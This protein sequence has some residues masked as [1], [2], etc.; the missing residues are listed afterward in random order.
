MNSKIDGH[1]CLFFFKFNDKTKRK[2]DIYSES[3]SVGHYSVIFPSSSSCSSDCGQSNSWKS[4]KP[5]K[6]STKK[7][8]KLNINLHRKITNKNRAL[9]NDWLCVFRVSTE[10]VSLAT[11]GAL[12]SKFQIRLDFTIQKKTPIK[13]QRLEFQSVSWLIISS[14]GWF[15]LFYGSLLLEVVE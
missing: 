7:T 15:H 1:L 8:N 13:C 14:S 6:S 2:E 4:M 9:L 10:N 12:L 11:G 3:C 5:I